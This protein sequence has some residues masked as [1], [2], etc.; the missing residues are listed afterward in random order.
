MHGC[1][2]IGVEVTEQ[3]TFLEKAITLLEEMN[4][5]LD[6]IVTFMK[7]P[8]NRFGNV[9]QT[10]GTVVGIFSILSIIDIILNWLGK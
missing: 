3:N 8:D 2:V 10:V 4:K 7:K 5:K 9:L 1:A 6:V